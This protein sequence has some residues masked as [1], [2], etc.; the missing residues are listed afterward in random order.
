MIGVAIE[1]PEINSKQVVRF[2]TMAY[3]EVGRGIYLAIYTIK[4][5]CTCSLKHEVSLIFTEIKSNQYGDN[6]YFMRT[7]KSDWLLMTSRELSGHVPYIW[8]VTYVFDI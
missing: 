3:I 6:D 8:L 4:C 7:R 1:W 2:F 5:N